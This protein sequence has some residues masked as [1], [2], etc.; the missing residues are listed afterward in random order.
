MIGQNA[1]LQQA[2]AFRGV[3]V[4]EIDA[5]AEADAL[6]GTLLEAGLGVVEV[7]FRREAARSVRQAG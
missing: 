2:C 6:A 5:L 4:V 7:T 1:T 3:P